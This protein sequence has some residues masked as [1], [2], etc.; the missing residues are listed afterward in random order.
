MMPA[1]I[2]TPRRLTLSAGRR[3]RGSITAPAAAGIAYSTAWVVG[4]A[5]WPSNLDVTAGNAKIVAT[6]RAHE[7]A[8]MTQYVLV[9][10]LAAVA[11]VVVAVLLGRA[12]GARHSP[13]LGVAMLVAGLGAAVL[14]MVECALGLRLAGSVAPNLE[15]ER[16]GR[17]FDLINRIDGLKM[18]ALA[19][20]AVAGF[21]LVRRAVLPH[22]LGYTAAAL[23]VALLASGT[24]YLLLNTTIAQAAYVSG[25]LLLVWVTGAGIA[26]A[27]THRSRAT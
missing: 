3:G 19:A 25:P 24:G 26:L 27:R 5:V 23:A 1:A 13:R 17:I 12:A 15:I 4:L 14:S 16:A 18:F 11:L 22:W 21:G 20:M 10:G 2:Q 6:Y 8:A 9:E 7:A